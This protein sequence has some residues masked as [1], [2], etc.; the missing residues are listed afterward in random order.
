MKVRCDCG[1]SGDDFLAKL[2]QVGWIQPETSR[3]HWSCPACAERAPRKQ[4]PEEA[5]PARVPVVATA[6]FR[7]ALTP[8][9]VTKKSGMSVVSA[10]DAAG[11]SGAPRGGVRSVGVWLSPSTPSPRDSS[12]PNP[13]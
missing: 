10:S 4:P 8:E 9:P 11:K 6:S 3:H 5:A 7:V 1:R 12:A 13:H 2:R